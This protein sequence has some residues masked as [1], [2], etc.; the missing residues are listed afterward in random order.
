MPPWIRTYKPPDLENFDKDAA[1]GG[2]LLED[3]DAE[4]KAKTMQAAGAAFIMS[5]HTEQ[6]DE[7][8]RKKEE[9]EKVRRAKRQAGRRSSPVPKNDH[10]FH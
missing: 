3:A 8:K 7:E 10:C 6:E 9:E 2:V 4:A 5:D 1:S